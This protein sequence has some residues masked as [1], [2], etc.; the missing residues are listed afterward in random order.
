MFSNY[1]LL[2]AFVKEVVVKH[3]A[4][5]DPSEPRDYIDSFLIE[6]MEVKQLLKWQ[7]N[8]KLASLTLTFIGRNAANYFTSSIPNQK[9]H[10]TT[11]GFDEENIVPCVLDLFLAGTE[12]T[13]TTLCWGLIYLITYPKVQGENTF[14]KESMQIKY[15]L[16]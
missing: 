9:P 6:M 4:S 14:F 10:E 5:L 15:I 12:T 2:Q 16:T 7:E 13:S 3:K 11:D 1:K 8:C